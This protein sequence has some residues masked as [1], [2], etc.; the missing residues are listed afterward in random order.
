MTLAQ[1]P[2]S[3]I[4]HTEGGQHPWVPPALGDK[5]DYFGPPEDGAGFE[6]TSG[7]CG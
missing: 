5:A 7:G 6:V 3:P 1:T 2:A 4:A